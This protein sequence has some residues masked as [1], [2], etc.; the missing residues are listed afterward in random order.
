MFIL[1]FWE[2]GYKKSYTAI[3]DEFLDRVYSLIF[4]K[5]CPILLYATKRVISRIGNWYLEEKST[6]LRDFWSHWGPVPIAILCTRQVGIGENLF[7]N[8]FARFQCL[9]GKR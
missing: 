1:A 4:K 5:K 3:C 7:P 2:N 9:L 8:Y 6:Y